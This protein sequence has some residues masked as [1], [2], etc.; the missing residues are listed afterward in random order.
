MELLLSCAKP[1]ICGWLSLKRLMFRVGFSMCH[2]DRD[3]KLDMNSSTLFMI[4]CPDYYIFMYMSVFSQDHCPYAPSTKQWTACILRKVSM[5]MS[6]KSQLKG[7]LDWEGV[8]CYL[9]HMHVSV[10]WGIIGSETII[11]VIQQLYI[12]NIDFIKTLIC[13]NTTLTLYPMINLSNW[14]ISVKGFSFAEIFV[15]VK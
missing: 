15:V 2:R 12:L 11:S 7:K 13:F 14:D 3:G 9:L 8:F 10:N 6:L 4:I 5:I 1:S